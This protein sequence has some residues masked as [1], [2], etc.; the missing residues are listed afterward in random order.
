MQKFIILALVVALFGTNVVAQQD[1]WAVV[2][3]FP[4][5]SRVKLTLANGQDVTGTVVEIQADAVA[6]TRLDTHGKGLTMPAS[7]SRSDGSILFL[8]ST[9]AQARKGGLSTGQKVAIVAGAAGGAVLI[10]IAWLLNG[11]R[12]S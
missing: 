6:M 1:V 12:N 2:Q 10:W 3:G 8:R 4:L 9:V 7:A 5:G 11:L